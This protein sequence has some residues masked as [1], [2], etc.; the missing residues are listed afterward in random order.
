MNEKNNA[1]RPV[2][3]SKSSG[4]Q[5]SIGEHPV[6]IE[7]T[8]AQMVA[9]AVARMQKMHF[10]EDRIEAFYEEGCVW[11][12]DWN[13]LSDEHITWLVDPLGYGQMI[14]AFEQRHTFPIRSNPDEEARPDGRVLVYS[15]MRDELPEATVYSMLTVDNVP[16]S[17]TSPEAYHGS[18]PSRYADLK[19][20]LFYVDAH[21]LWIPADEDRWDDID[22]YV[23]NEGPVQ[24]VAKKILIDTSRGF[25]RRIDGGRGAVYPDASGPEWMFCRI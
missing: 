24:H 7:A 18:I 5:N 10:D 11:I 21:T 22:Y 13:D 15:I 20:S 25:P 23:H 3:N 4:E 16:A 1:Y 12:T 9:E 17:W 14:E 6:L 2:N 8:R 19:E